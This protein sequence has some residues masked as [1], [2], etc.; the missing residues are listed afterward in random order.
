MNAWCLLEVLS[1]SCMK[2]VTYENMNIDNIRLPFANFP[3]IE[4]RIALYDF[5]FLATPS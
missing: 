1:H 3:P 2:E 4:N 5:L